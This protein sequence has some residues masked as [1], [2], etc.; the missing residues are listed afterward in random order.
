VAEP[1]EVAAGV[2]SV[3]EL[4]LMITVTPRVR[5]WRLLGG[6]SDQLWIVKDVRKAAVSGGAAR[7]R[8]RHQSRSV[9]SGWGRRGHV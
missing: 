3:D 4:A 5:G 2:V 8:G 1:V 7:Q 9:A 6:G